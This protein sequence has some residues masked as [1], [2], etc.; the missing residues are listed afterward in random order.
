[1][2][3]AIVI[4]TTLVLGKKSQV[5]E[6]PRAILPN[7][8]RISVVPSTTCGHGLEIALSWIGLCEYPTIKNGRWTTDFPLQFPQLWR[9]LK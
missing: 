6:F 8:I 3:R 7:R 5:A 2:I 9:K 1:M 4:S